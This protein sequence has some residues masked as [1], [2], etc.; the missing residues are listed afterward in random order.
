MPDTP[1]PSPTDTT[2]DIPAPGGGE[3]GR[4]VRAFDWSRTPLGPLESWPVSLRTTVG[5]VLQ[6][7]VPM[8]LLWGSDGVMIYNDGY[9]VFAAD[10][11][12]SMLGMKVVEAWPEAASFNSNVMQVCLSGQTLSYKDQHFILYRNDRAESVWM[13]L[14]YSP[15]FD[16]LGHP[17]GVIA[18]VVE[19]TER[20][21]ADRRLAAEHE[22]LTRLFEQAP[23][24]MAML[25]G[26]DH[27]FELANPGYLSLIGERQVIGKPLQE[28]LPEVIEQG[29]ATF[30]D[31]AFRSGQA[32]NGTGVRIM[33]QRRPNAEPEER[34]VDFVYQPIKDDD[35]CVT[36][37]FVQG[38][39]VTERVLAERRQK[40]LMNEL[41][42]RVKNTLATVFSLATRTLKE[43][44]SLP[45][46]SEKL[47][48]R[49][50]ALSRAQDVLTSE[51]WDGADMRAMVEAALRAHG[52][53]GGGRFSIEGPEV[54][55]SPRAVMS[56]SLAVH[57]LSTNA[58][59]Y[60]ALST[61]G[62]RI[63]VL[64]QL[65]DRNNTPTLLFRWTESGGPPVQPP[66][67]RGFGS[68][69]IER[70]LAMELG[71][72]AVIDYPPSGVVFTL[73]TA[74]S[75]VTEGEAE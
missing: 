10:R 34:F 42:H 71:G 28:A 27:V 21:L 60:G 72:T 68:T 14:D 73:E 13:N 8:V 75:A 6:T 9:R 66:H 56:L 7:P 55:L 32:F 74:L 38:S 35:D 22:R 40:L 12:P 44:D 63:S 53:P 4:L 18:V 70:G 51:S 20:V 31:T 33:L 25:R 16:E 43:A 26:R 58:A 50:I 23:S 3:M 45:V 19:T 36:H 57:E 15:V 41:N 24:F 67:R 65:E 39:D 52:D 48:D 46:A 62:G 29:F 5:I 59:K 17:A 37:I 11:H 69:L 54:A 1:E 30:L 61:E 64:W 47:R 2:H 49:I